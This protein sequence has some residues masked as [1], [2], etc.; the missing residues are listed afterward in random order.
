[1]ADSDV[2]E[3]LTLKSR[4][5]QTKWIADHLAVIDDGFVAA[6]KNEAI[7]LRMVNTHRALSIARLI[8]A[9]FRRTGV[10][11]HRGFGL[12]A[13][14]VV[15]SLCLGE[16]KR[17]LKKYDEAIAIFEKDGDEVSPALMQISRLWSLA[18]LNR[19]TEAFAAGEAAAPVLAAHERWLP[20]A[21]LHNN[22]ASVY[23]R[24]GEYARALSMLESAQRAYESFG[25]DSDEVESLWA[26]AVNNR[27]I[28]LCYLGRFDESIEASG[29]AY[30]TLER[31]GNR[32]EAARVQQHLAVTYLILGRYNE[33]LRLLDQVRDLFA[34]DGQQRHAARV[35]L[36]ICECLLRLRRFDRVLDKVPAILKTFEAIQARHEQG[37]A[38]LYAAVA[39]AGEDD[40]PSALETLATAQQLFEEENNRVWQ[41]NCD[42]ES[43]QIM[44]RLGRL[45]EC[46]RKALTAADRFRDEGLR[47]REAE[48]L[49]WAAEA[50]LLQGDNRAAGELIGAAR[51]IGDS[52][53]VPLL[54]F[55]IHHLLGRVARA[56]ADLNRSFT[57]LQ[58]A[59]VAV[60]RLRAH[61]M[62]DLRVNF[63]EDKQ[64]LYEDMVQVCLD[65]QQPERA[66]HYADRVKSRTLLE[67]ID[68]RVE[69]RLHAR[70]PADQPLVD[71]LLALRARRDQLCRH[72]E[73]RERTVERS[74]VVRLS[75]ED[76]R[77]LATLDK[78]IAQLW[79]T[80]LI[81]NA[82]YAEEAELW[83]ATE[84]PLHLSLDSAIPD[85]AALVEYFSIHG[86]FI[87][88]V[89][90]RGQVDVFPLN[91]DVAHVRRLVERLHQHLRTVPLFPAQRLPQLTRQVQHLLH[92]LY[93][94]L[95][96][97]V[98]AA[99]QPFRRLIIV[100]HDV[101]HYTPFHALFDGSTY[102]VEHHDISYLPNAALLRRSSD[103]TL[104]EPTERGSGV[105]AMGFSADNSLP[106]VVEEAQAVARLFGGEAFVEEDAARGALGALVGD[107]QILHLAAHA[108]FNDDQPLFSGLLLAGGWLTTLDVFDMQLKADLVTL[109]AC[110]TGRSVLG[111]GDELLGLMRAFLYAGAA[112]LVMSMWSVE[113]RSTAAFMQEFY[114]H[115]QGGCSKAQALSLTQRH[116]VNGG[117]GAGTDE[118]ADYTHPYF[119]APFFL[120]GDPAAITWQP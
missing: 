70:Q 119:W 1:M 22:L 23:T 83:Q 14:A 93:T 92:Q 46:Y 107:K 33:S 3:L 108:E 40:L 36:Y 35:D 12:W 44:S 62:I 8:L 75:E 110:Q 91:A 95:V 81:R 59:I 6:L 9:I 63:Q 41:A 19:Y 118:E 102:L 52:E 64:T 78:E 85:D 29:I 58:Q 7:Q 99:L 20:A 39:H 120:V 117:P 10:A 21:T 42:M 24:L 43:A 45:E 98:A 56:E 53:T 32:S 69:M 55:Q 86:S 17:A 106:F 116:F 47:V 54:L 25:L 109:S 27:A 84:Q 80:L 101:L 65:L 94:I 11:R 68:Y 74:G 114:R 28:S 111:G 82:D 105:L 76:Q 88:F 72:S 5:Q 73:N 66:L 49:V 51:V 18:N 89:A 48:A 90:R 113:D 79:D 57:E 112:S 26:F 104:R 96:A 38:L 87:A 15:R 31:L 2:A 30:S 13:E 61:L 71:R 50:R 60:E 103:R 77:Q 34:A 115:L 4:S 37:I 16:Y 100:P 67:M 97:P